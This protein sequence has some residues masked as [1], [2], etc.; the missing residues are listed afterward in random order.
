[1]SIQA[2]QAQRL[3]EVNVIE[4]KDRKPP[5]KRSESSKISTHIGFIKMRGHSWSDRTPEPLIEVSQNNPGAKQFVI[6]NDSAIDQFPGLFALFEK[7]G[8][9]MN[10]EHVEKVLV[11]PKV[12]TQAAAPLSPS[13]GDVVVLVALYGQ[14]GQ[15]DIPVPSA[16]VPAILAKSKVKSQFLSDKPCLILFRGPAL[17]AYNFL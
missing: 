14:A 2:F 4:R 16:L 6:G 5:R 11:K 7:P 15:Q 1:M 10:V 9:K 17:E 13:R 3:I 12:G 8:S